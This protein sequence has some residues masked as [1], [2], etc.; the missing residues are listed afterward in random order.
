VVAGNGSLALRQALL[1][2]MF[3]KR[4]DGQYRAQVD[5][6]NEKGVEHLLGWHGE[7]EDMTWRVR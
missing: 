7:I 5:R 6:K 1:H 2:V 4:D 3:G